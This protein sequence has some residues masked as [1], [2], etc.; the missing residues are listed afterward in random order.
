[1]RHREWLWIWML[2]ILLSACGHPAAPQ[3]ELEIICLDVGQGNSTLLRTVEGDVLID[4]GP[5]SSQE[6]LCRRL[7]ALG[8]ESVALLVFTH[9]DEDH[10]GGGDGVLRQFP[11]DEVWVN[12]TEAENESFFRLKDE[13]LRTNIAGRIVAAGDFAMFGRTAVT[14]LSPPPEGAVDGN[15]GSLVLSVRCGD[16]SM[17]LMGDTGKSTEEWLLQAYGPSQLRADVLHVGHHGSD[18]AGHLEFLQAAAPKAAVISCEAGNSYGHPDGRTLAR[19]ENAG[20]EIY[21]TDLLGE[22]QIDAN[23]DDF[24]ISG[25]HP[26]GGE[27]TG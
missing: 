13:L 8:V 3:A 9:P 1:M 17:L 16:F 15:E 27:A 25:S 26:G 5:E 11:V 7:S 6:Q 19:L 2:A 18:S 4:A 14:V 20:A 23:G 22:I 10:I 24:R 12:G 21:R